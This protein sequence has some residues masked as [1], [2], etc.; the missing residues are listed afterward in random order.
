MVKGT[1]LDNFPFS[2]LTRIETGIVIEA[3]MRK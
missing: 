2:L 1:Q 3:E